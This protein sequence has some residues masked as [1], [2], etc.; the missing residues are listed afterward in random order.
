MYGIAEI[1]EHAVAVAGTLE[2]GTHWAAS[3]MRSS[4]SGRWIRLQ[5]YHRI[6][7]PSCKL[8]PYRGVST[9]VQTDTESDRKL[10]V[11]FRIA[12]ST[13]IQGT[14]SSRL[15]PQT[16]KSHSRQQQCIGRSCAVQNAGCFR[17]R[18]VRADTGPPPPEEE[19]SSP[20]ILC[21]QLSRLA[22]K[23]RVIGIGIG[24]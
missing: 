23:C 7:P 13:R 3:G 5:L 6:L 18:D 12:A 10:C 8:R 4:R 24:D 15:P 9:C 20:R 19:A 16:W 22:L 11:C 1:C 14:P 21:K 17:K 2:L